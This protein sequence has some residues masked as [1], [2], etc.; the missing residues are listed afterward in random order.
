MIVRYRPMQPNDVRECAE[1]VAVHPIL[2]A[3]YGSSI[4]D[5]PR[6][7]LSLM[8]RDAFG[9]AVFEELH[10]SKARILGASAAVFVREEFLRELKTPPFFWAGPELVN[11]LTRGESPVLSDKEVREANSSG[12]LNLVIW[13]NGVRLDDLKRSEVGNMCVTAFIQS[14][15]GFFLKELIWTGGKPGT[16]SRHA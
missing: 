14:Y 8:G 11:R 7:L 2:G 5:L 15:R 9:A 12:G 1:I 3:R 6:A 4:A 10:E 16:L 13:Q